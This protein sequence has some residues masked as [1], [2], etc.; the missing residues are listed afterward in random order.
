MK[1]LILS[2]IFLLGFVNLFSQ[3]TDSLNGL[4][5]K[6][7]LKNTAE[8]ACKCIDKIKEKGKSANEVAALI[9]DCIDK[10]VT[11][12]QLSKKLFSTKKTI[13]NGDNKSDTG[14]ITIYIST[15]K[16]SNDY[17]K[18]YYDIERYLMENCKS[19]KSKVV[20]NDKVGENSLSDKKSALKYYNKGI[21]ESEKGEYA[22]ALVYFEKSVAI[23]SSS[24]FAWDNIGVCNRKLGN[25]DA[26]LTAY[27]KS[28]SIDPKGPMPLQNIAVVYEF[29][30]Q[31]DDAIKAYE[32][33]VSVDSTNPE[34]YFGLGKIYSAYLKEYEKGLDNFCKAYNLYIQLKSPYRTDAEKMINFIYSE[35]KKEGKE[36]RVIEILK[37]NHISISN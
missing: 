20:V 24:A 31:Y 28:L 18:Y 15:D 14:K 17:K 16:N 34:S 4:L 9:G 26:A 11:A 5:G 33:L 19:I 10:E 30:K 36:K 25:L 7:A 32:R 12:Y 37:E 27:K 29:K 3:D 21:T 6:T 13:E 1:R 8:N 2:S 22:K 35:M 23:D